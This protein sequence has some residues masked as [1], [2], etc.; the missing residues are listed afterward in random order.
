MHT[1]LHKRVATGSHGRSARQKPVFS[2]L[3]RQVKP[4]GRLI[5]GGVKGVGNITYL[6]I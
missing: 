2:R 1:N 6:A 3:E 5:C 4:D